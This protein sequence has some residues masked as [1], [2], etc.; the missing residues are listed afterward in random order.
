MHTINIARR[1]ASFL[2]SRQSPDLLFASPLKNFFLLQV[3]YG[4]LLLAFV[5]SGSIPSAFVCQSACISYSAV[6]ISFG[7]P[8]QQQPL[9]IISLTLESAA[10]SSTARPTRGRNPVCLSVVYLSCLAPWAKVDESSRLN[11][12]MPKERYQLNLSS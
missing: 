4:F 1:G 8:K 2:H 5:L 12:V 6:R 3:F 11:H 9:T 7:C 10:L